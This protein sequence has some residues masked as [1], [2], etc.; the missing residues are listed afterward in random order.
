MREEVGSLFNAATVG[1]DTR[2]FSGK[3]AALDIEEMVGE[4]DPLA[5]KRLGIGECFTTGVEV[6]L[7]IELRLGVA[8]GLDFFDT[9]PGELLPLTVGSRNLLECGLFVLD[10]I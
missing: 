2:L 10:C 3:E 9:C 6:I 7:K 8:A 4:A 1:L 5:S